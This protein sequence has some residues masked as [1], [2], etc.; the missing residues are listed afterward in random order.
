MNN[1]KKVMAVLI[2]TEYINDLKTNDKICDRNNR[3]YF[4]VDNYI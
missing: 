3:Y 1:E 4:L 2:M